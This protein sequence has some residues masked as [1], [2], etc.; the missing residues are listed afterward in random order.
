MNRIEAAIREGRCVLAI[1]KQALSNPEVLAELRHRSIPAV[2]LGGNATNPVSSLSAENLS[3]ALGK[4]GGVLVL[5]EPDGA[6]D[7]RAL[8]E[9][10]EIIKA[11]GT[12]PKLF[13]AARARA[14]TKSLGL[15]PAALMISPSSFSARPSE[16]PSGSTR[17][18]TP[19][20][21][22]K[23]AER[24]S[25]LSED[26]GL[27]ALPPRV[28]AGIDRWRNSAS[29]SGL[30]RACLPMARTQRPSRMA[31]SMRFMTTPQERWRF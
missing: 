2:T 28:T 29:T 6:S 19:P 10:G 23:A 1:G 13:V 17:T 9:L 3:A 15:V 5:V 8:N 30:L 4:A 21:F 11:A 31:A 16:A 27:V 18:R 26:T 7:G 22:P 25:A 20:A 12:K 24:F 14:A